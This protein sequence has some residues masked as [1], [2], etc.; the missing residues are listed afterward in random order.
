MNQKI[1]QVLPAAIQHQLDR[2]SA[3]LQRLLGDDLTGIYLHGSLAMGCFH[4][5]HSD[6][7]LLVTIEK[8]LSIE[9]KRWL[10]EMLLKSSMAPSPIE[11]S[12]LTWEH[13][14]PWKHPAP[15]DLHYSEDWRAWLE[16]DLATDAW[17]AW[18]TSD[19]TDLDLAAHI[20]VLHE[21]GVVL[22]G[23]PISQMLPPVPREHYINSILADYRWA[24]E[25][26]ERDPVYGVLNMVRVLHYL[27]E[28]T[29]SS[30]EE[31]GRW[32]MEVLPDDVRTVVEVALA[33]YRGAS[34]ERALQSDGLQKF[35][36]EIDG[37]VT[38]LEA[39]WWAS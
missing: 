20:T 9:T 23:P 32:A 31:A 8:P 37:R 38:P 1:P 33:R 3:E 2:L 17:R 25:R 22:L 21:R 13:L 7:D 5:H 14:H 34:D 16:S 30:K 36:D 6:I 11:I 35:A 26:I 10:S 27:V 18:D 15:Y 39:E 4:P 29:V 19:A 28:G 24:R 12:I